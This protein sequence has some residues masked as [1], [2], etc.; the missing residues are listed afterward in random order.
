MKKGKINSE[1]VKYEN[2][3]VRTRSMGLGLVLIF[4]I[5]LLLVRIAFIQILHGDEYRTITSNQQVNKNNQIISPIRGSMSDRNGYDNRHFPFHVLKDLL[6]FRSHMR[7][8]FLCFCS[9][10]K[11]IHPFQLQLPFP[12]S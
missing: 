4:V 7:K 3:K 12:N 9:G 5:F 2:K 1:R 10:G 8:K 6:D 11:R